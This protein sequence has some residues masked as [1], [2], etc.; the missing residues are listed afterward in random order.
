MTGDIRPSLVESEAWLEYAL[1]LIDG[2]RGI[3]FHDLLLEP[4]ARALENRLLAALSTSDVD[5]LVSESRGGDPASA[6]AAIR[7]L[8][9]LA[10]ASDARIAP[11]AAVVAHA[12]SATTRTRYPHDLGGRLALLGWLQTRPAEASDFLRNHAIEDVLP[13]EVEVRYPIS[14]GGEV[15]LGPGDVVCRINILDVPPPGHEDE[16]GWFIA[17]VDVTDDVGRVLRAHAPLSSQCFLE[18]LRMEG[19][20]PRGEAPILL[21]RT[22][23]Y[24]DRR[25]WLPVIAMSEGRM[26]AYAYAEKYFHLTV[27]VRRDPVVPRRIRID[28]P[29]GDTGIGHSSAKWLIPEFSVAGSF[30]ARAILAPTGRWGV[31]RIRFRQTSGFGIAQSCIRV[32]GT[33]GVARTDDHSL[34]FVLEEIL[35]DGIDGGLCGHAHLFA[36][37]LA[38]ARLGAAERH[39]IAV[40]PS[41]P[42]GDRLTCALTVLARDFGSTAAIDRLRA[43]GSRE[44]SVGDNAHVGLA[45]LGHPDQARIARGIQDWRDTRSAASLSWL[46]SMSKAALSFEGESAN[47]V[48][49]QIRAR[50]GAPSREGAAFLAYESTDGHV[51]LTITARQAPDRSF[52]TEFGTS[53]KPSRSTGV[54]LPVK[55]YP[56]VSLNLGTD[57]ALRLD[58]QRRV[59]VGVGG[60]KGR[61]SLEGDAPYEISPENSS[62]RLVFT[63]ADDRGFMFRASR[64]ITSRLL[65]DCWRLEMGLVCTPE[66]NKSWSMAAAVVTT[67]DRVRIHWED[68]QLVTDHYE[69]NLRPYLLDLSSQV[70]LAEIRATPGSLQVRLSLGDEQKHVAAFFS[71]TGIATMVLLPSLLGSRD[72]CLAA[73]HLVETGERGEPCQSVTTE[74]LSPPPDQNRGL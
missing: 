60:L 51:E 23:C 70:T 24:S 42:N 3:G 64:A 65:A 29:A 4:Q 56:P 46:S 68:V 52:R 39:L 21:G 36:G 11:R 62:V 67:L 15:V 63:F 1:N 25:R 49:A 43:L 61:L 47:D 9:R 31:P 54:A 45:H 41:S 27:D 53:W 6:L 71:C 2:H 40:E 10:L 13:L 44:G 8:L 74:F 38:G 7:L 22:R 30:L 66:L 57:I 72:H 18:M 37:W 14:D 59:R 17:R 34:L 20:V 26:A 35:R 16:H 55:D 69:D 12:F 48:F 32:Q 5:A 58:D 50:L 19:P 33:S 73:T 28:V